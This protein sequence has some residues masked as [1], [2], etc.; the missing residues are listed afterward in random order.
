MAQSRLPDSLT[1]I[2]LQ[3]IAGNM[4]SVWL[5]DYTDKYMEEHMFMYIEGPFNQLAGNMVQELI[6]ILGDSHKLTRAAL[7]LLLQPHLTQL[8]LR[9][10]AG[11]VNNT[12]AQLVSM[13]CKSLT[14]LDLHSCHRVGAP[15]LTLLV[16]RLPR[17]VKLCL[18][19]T[20]CDALVLSAVGSRC[21]R[22]REL[23]VSRCRKVTPLSLLSLG[24]N[25]KE[26]SFRGQA[27]R[28]L[29]IRDVIS[30]NC[31]EEWVHALTFLLLALP[32]LELLSHPLLPHALRLLHGQRFGCAGRS[33]D[34]FPSLAEVAR[35]RTAKESLQN[36]VTDLPSHAPQEQRAGR[37]GKG[38]V[39]LVLPLKKLEDLE[40]PDV[41]LL[42]CLCP[43]V[44][45]VTISLGGQAGPV[46][47]L[48][49]WP[50]LSRLTLHCPEHPTRSLEELLPPL[51]GVA[52][53]L[54]FLSIQN[55]VWGEEDSLSTLLSLCSDL[56]TFQGHLAPSRRTWPQNE[57]ELPPWG[58]DTIPLP[59]L[60]IFSLLMEE[61]EAW[62]PRL[63]HSLGGSLVSVLRG[64]PELESL[65]LVG[66]SC[67]LDLV[68][69]T[70]FALVS[71]PLFP[72]LKEVSL[73]RSLV[74][75]AGASALLRLKGLK[76]L[77]LSHCQDVTRRDHHRLQEK[78]QKAGLGVL[79]SWQ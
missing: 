21:Q 74:S 49:Q 47:S 28:G 9:P 45:D 42:G 76:V 40:E 36:G 22:L 29:L 43:G 51:G 1:S 41:S 7:H 60:K 14:S 65:S 70:T 79:I 4:H 15:S 3:N 50:S 17:L 6:K 75:A 62:P 34:G 18:S 5:T 77:D 35:A 33:P 23:D 56:H 53:R 72:K 20:Q 55:L 19:D 16:E 61:G 59:R 2:C 31:P 52:R 73:R 66:V 13:R 78:A 57:A 25:C 27:L 37:R 46:W 71:P 39:G 63:Q 68:F 48:M 69:Q 24:Y 32:R 44:E 30:Q 54:R 64:S 26:G 11:L 10:C 12:I 38:V 58:E 67:N 8:S